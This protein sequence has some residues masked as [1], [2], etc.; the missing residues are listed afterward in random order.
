MWDLIVSVPDH[1]LSFYLVT[2]KGTVV[3]VELML[4]SDIL[5]N[6]TIKLF[7]VRHLEKSFWCKCYAAHSN[8]KYSCIQVEK[9]HPCLPGFLFV[10]G[11][12]WLL[13]GGGIF[14]YCPDKP[15]CSHSYY[16]STNNDECLHLS[17]FIIKLWT[18]VKMSRLV[19]KLTMWHMRPA[20]TQSLSCQHEES[21][22]P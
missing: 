18:L 12:T 15:L 1:C 4:A 11:N 6:W 3:T 22:G 2:C 17:S 9:Y 10:R 19:T 7:L 16:G 14:P 20:K 13:E 5:C 8:S 21:L